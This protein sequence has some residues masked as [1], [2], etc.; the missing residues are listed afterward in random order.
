MAIIQSD[1][2]SQELAYSVIGDKKLL[3]CYNGK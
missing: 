2:I 1:I 3:K